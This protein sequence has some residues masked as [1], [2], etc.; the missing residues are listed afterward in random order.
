MRI[1]RMRTS[2]R[3]DNGDDNNDNNEYNNED[4]G[5]V[6]IT[7]TRDANDDGQG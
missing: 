3:D 6:H 1:T 5:Q 7:R 4:A 2:D